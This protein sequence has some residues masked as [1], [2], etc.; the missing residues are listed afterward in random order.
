MSV[1]EADELLL[2]QGLWPRCTDGD[3]RLFGPRDTRGSN[4]RPVE[5]TAQERA[6]GRV[7]GTCDVVRPEHDGSRRDGV[8][9]L[10]HVQRV[11][12][13]TGG[14]AGIGGGLAGERRGT[15]AHARVAG[16][17]RGPTLDGFFAQLEFLPAES[18]I[19]PDRGESSTSG[20][21]PR[22]NRGC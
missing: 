7:E 9:V 1:A 16:F 10:R 11:G 8:G 5:V 17:R 13:E 22:R 19:R 6:H 21:L 14:R 18:A 4:Q 3:A 20:P 12:H 2:A 15:G